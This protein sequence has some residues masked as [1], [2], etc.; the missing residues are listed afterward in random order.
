MYLFFTAQWHC[1]SDM[2]LL[3]LVHIKQDQKQA[4][5]FKSACSAWVREAT[6]T[7]SSSRSAFTRQALRGVLGRVSVCPLAGAHVDGRR[8]LSPGIEV[9]CNIDPVLER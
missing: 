8:H 2:H 6:G 9:L 4:G 7:A 5:R 3:D 1:V